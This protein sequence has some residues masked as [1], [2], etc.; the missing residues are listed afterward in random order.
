MNFFWACAIESNFPL[1]TQGHRETGGNFFEVLDIKEAWERNIVILR[2]EKCENSSNSRTCV[3]NYKA[4]EN[5]K[6]NSH[7]SGPIQALSS[8]KKY[9]INF[10]VKRH[11]PDQTNSLKSHPKLLLDQTFLLTPMCDNQASF[12]NLFK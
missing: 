7:K 8:R 9:S 1:Q 6:N 12:D 4:K 3:E 5:P 10:F 2:P 11:N